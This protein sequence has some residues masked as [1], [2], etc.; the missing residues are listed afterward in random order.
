METIIIII[1]II[2]LIVLFKVRSDYIKSLEK[3][4]EEKEEEKKQQEFTADAIV[5]VGD[6][7]VPVSFRGVDVKFTQVEDRVDYYNVDDD[8]LK[9]ACDNSQETGYGLALVVM[10][11]GQGEYVVRTYFM[12]IYAFS[13]NQESVCVHE[14]FPETLKRVQEAIDAVLPIR[15]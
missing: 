11:E 9:I 2:A 5:K 12:A 8:L 10:R 14:E 4:L 6:H 7:E 15:R 3:Q 13:H 1:G